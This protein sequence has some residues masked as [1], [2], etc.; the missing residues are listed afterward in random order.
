VFGPRGVHVEAADDVAHALD[1]AMSIT[2]AADAVLVT[3]SI[4]TVA[5]AREHLQ[6][7]DELRAESDHAG[8]SGGM[9]TLLV[10]IG[11]AAEDGEDDVSAERDALGQDGYGD[12]GDDEGR[13]LD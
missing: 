6:P 9:R 13:V 2:G 11:D 3:G 1:L 12:D 7:S 10:G 5:A 4:T 8:V